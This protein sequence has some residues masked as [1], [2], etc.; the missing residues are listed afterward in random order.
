MDLSPVVTQLRNECDL[1]R[2]VE[3]VVSGAI[4]AAYPQAFVMAVAEAAEP[5]G[6]LGAHTQRVT[7]RVGV[8][9]RL[10]ATGGAGGASA[11][12]ELELVRRQ[13]KNALIGWQPTGGD[14]PFNFQQG[15]M[16]EY[17]PGR[18]VW[19]DIYA[20]DYYEDHGR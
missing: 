4:P 12:D 20:L 16:V 5:N 8:E 10:K 9:I 13:V 2:G 17:E 19:R 6:L 15:A 7:V 1:L 3:L 18:V 14:T 11:T